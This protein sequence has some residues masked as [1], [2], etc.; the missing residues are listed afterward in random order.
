M[1]LIDGYIGPQQPDISKTSDITKFVAWSST[2]RY[3][4]LALVPRSNSSVVSI[5]I[6]LLNNP[7]IEIG[8]P[9]FE[10][11]GSD[12]ALSVTPQSKLDFDI[13][14]NNKRSLE[15]NNV[16]RISLHIR[17]PSLYNAFFLRWNFDNLSNVS[18]LMISEIILCK[19]LLPT[20]QHAENNNNGPTTEHAEIKKNGQTKEEH[21]ENKNNG[22]AKT[23]K[24]SNLGKNI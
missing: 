24:L 18:W 2:S 21:A 1:V 17:S 6:Y 14:T 10:L 13:V 23:G 8:V 3:S 16:L 19:G 20:K 11:F 4:Y 22:S 15:D 7:K 9:N 5:E 12:N